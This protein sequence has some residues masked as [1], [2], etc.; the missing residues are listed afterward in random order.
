MKVLVL[1]SNGFL[2]SHFKSFKSNGTTNDIEIESN[3]GKFSN[4]DQISSLQIS[5]YDWI[6]NCIANASIDSCE[7]NPISASWLNTDFPGALAQEARK[8]NTRLV[9]FSTDAVFSGKES[10]PTESSEP[11]PFSIYGKSKLAGENRVLEASSQNLICRVNFVGR[12]P[13][14]NSLFDFFYDALSDGKNVNGYSNVK[15]APLY[16]GDLVEAVLGMINEEKYG[17]YHLTGPVSM[18]KYDF[19]KLIA[20]QMNLNPEL[21]RFSLLEQNEGSLVR[22][23]NLCLSNEK[24]KSEGIQLPSPD[25]GI[26]KLI[27][28]L[29]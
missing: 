19:G 22:S 9:H 17:I 15:F 27:D 28:S 4:R 7:A 21:V 25:H 6:I 1:G 13:K 5:K 2:G 14:R 24:A 23:L 16:V 12:S 3:A 26:R 29:R 8:S 10:L 18:S 11:D 20:T